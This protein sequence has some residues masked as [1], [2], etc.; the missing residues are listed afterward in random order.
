[1]VKEGPGSFDLSLVFGLNAREKK[2]NEASN[3]RTML[4]SCILIQ[5]RITQ[6]I[7][8]VFV[9]LRAMIRVCC[10]KKRERTSES[11]FSSFF[12]NQNVFLTFRI[13]TTN[14]FIDLHNSLAILTRSARSLSCDL[15]GIVADSKTR[16]SSKVVI[17]I[18]RRKRSKQWKKP[19]FVYLNLLSSIRNAASPRLFTHFQINRIQNEQIL[20]ESKP[21]WKVW[22][23]FC[24]DYFSTGILSSQRGLY[25][26]LASFVFEMN[27][28]V[29]HKI[30]IGHKCLSICPSMYQTCDLLFVFCLD[31]V[32]CKTIFAMISLAFPNHFRPL[33]YLQPNWLRMS[34]M[35]SE[36]LNCISINMP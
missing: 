33:F 10:W 7:K 36:S 18:P 22:S 8:N 14:M 6:E 21:V 16:R 9:L 28:L 5:S 35:K 13:I 34:I 2:T 26:S 23:V 27:D 19:L 12:S 4:S 17:W 32:I 25:W 29:L 31:F 20:K 30:Q 24:L 11:T 1:M 3:I 15:Y